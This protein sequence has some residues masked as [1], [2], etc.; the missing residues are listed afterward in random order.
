MVSSTSQPLPIIIMLGVSPSSLN[1]RNGSPGILTQHNGQ[2]LDHSIVHEKLDW[3]LR[4]LVDLSFGAHLGIDRL[5]KGRSMC[6]SKKL[7]LRGLVLIWYHISEVL[8]S[9]IWQPSLMWYF[10]SFS[11]FSSSKLTWYC[12]YVTFWESLCV[13]IL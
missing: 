1:G 6:G 12:D 9:L 4:F 5:K 2:G 11:N 3:L 8:T 10:L 13:I 7:G